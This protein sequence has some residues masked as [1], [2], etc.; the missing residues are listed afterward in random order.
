MNSYRK[1]HRIKKKKPIYKNRIFLLAIFFAI[2]FGGIFYL[3]CFFPYFQ[4]EKINIS[5]NQKVS[6]DNIKNII[7]SQ[8]EQRILF[9]PSKSIF[10]ADLNEASKNILNGFP[11]IAE[12]NIKRDFFDELDVVVVERSVLANF[13]Q[14]NRCFSIDK[15]GII[16]EENSSTT[17]FIKIID[18]K[19][20]TTFALGEKVME[21][22]QLSEIL[23][24]YSKLNTDLNIPAKEFTISSEDRLIVLTQEGWEIYFYLKG[25]ISWQMTKLKAVLDEKIPQERRKD[26]QYIELRFE[27]LA[28]FKYKI[29]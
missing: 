12:I 4:I 5:G 14:D 19:S 18:K 25:D 3:S 8:V 27:N 23:D 29:K 15:E 7:Q 16:F 11:Q 17:D 28:P 6:V 10:L 24:I 20:T 1:P 13:C 21:K 2:I 22:D 26:L 9:L